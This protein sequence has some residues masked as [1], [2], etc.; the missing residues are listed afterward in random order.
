MPLLRILL[1][2]PSEQFWIALFFAVNFPI[3]LRRQIIE[4]AFLLPLA[5][6]C[7]QRGVLIEPFNSRRVPRPPYPKRTDT[8]QHIRLRLLYFFIHPLDQMIY[9]LAPPIV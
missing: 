9:I 2:P 5:C 7:I 8:D 6:V 4:P 1:G 3:K